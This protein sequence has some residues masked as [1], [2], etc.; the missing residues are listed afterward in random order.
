MVPTISVEMTA[1]RQFKTLFFE[2]HH[3]GRPLPHVSQRECGKH[4]TCAAPLPFCFWYRNCHQ[5]LT[6]AAHGIPRIRALAQRE[7]SHGHKPNHFG[8]LSSYAAP[9]PRAFPRHLLICFSHETR[10]HLWRPLDRSCSHRRGSRSVPTV[11]R[12]K[13]A[14]QILCSFFSRFFATAQCRTRVPRI[15]VPRAFPLPHAALGNS[16]E[17]I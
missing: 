10:S 13:P 7:I 11:S 9:F 5:S 4:T 12:D 17:P 15:P 14:A 6:Q 3:R 8:A 16:F 1:S 2:S